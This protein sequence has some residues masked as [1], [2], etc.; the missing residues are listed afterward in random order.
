MTRLV[1]ILHV[2]DDPDISDVVKLSLTVLGEFKID[3][4]SS[5]S[6][7]VKLAA[8]LSS[9]LLLLDMMMPGLNGLE[10][11]AKLRRFPQFADTPAILC[12]AKTVD[13]PSPE[14]A[15]VKGI[16]GT[17]HK[18]FEATDLAAQIQN[19]WDIH[20]AKRV[21]SIALPAEITGQATGP[22]IGVC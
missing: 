3:R 19:M 5:G 9:D 18:P 15:E 13:L 8:D 6:E 22:E 4:Y 7:V 2:E 14:A 20:A 17:I 12:T 16:I 1:H 11:L 21:A 10:T